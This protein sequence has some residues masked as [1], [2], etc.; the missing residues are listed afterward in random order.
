MYLTGWMRGERRRLGS[1]L[2][3]ALLTQQAAGAVHAFHPATL[4]GLSDAVASIALG[5]VGDGA[6]K[7]PPTLKRGE[8]R[9]RWATTVTFDH[10]QDLAVIRALATAESLNQRDLIV[11]ALRAWV[12]AN[13]DT[14]P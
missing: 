9:R 6:G 1:H 7:I 13:Y 3:P 12:A 14:R 10:A 11:Q 2:D 8:T 5:L 4:P